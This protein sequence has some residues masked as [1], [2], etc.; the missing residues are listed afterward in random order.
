MNSTKPKG[1]GSVSTPL[2]RAL[3][4]A[5]GPVTV[6]ELRRASRAKAVSVQ[7]R[8][9]RWR[10]AGFVVTLEPEPA[11][12]VI[13]PKAADRQ[14]APGPGDLSADAWRA[15]RRLGRPATFEELLAA[16]GAADRPLYCRLFR[17]RK[18]GFIVKIEARPSRYV[19]SPAA[20]DVAEPPQVS[21]EGEVKE[22]RRTARERLWSA[23]RVLKTFDV[24]MLMM[25]AEAR[26][27]SCEDFINLLARAGY[28]RT[29]NHPVT[30]S[31]AGNNARTWSTYQLTRNTG[32]KAPIIT[33]PRGGE[34]QLVDL[35]TG[36][37]VPIGP[38]LHQRARG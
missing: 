28:L 15:L 12:Y 35:N 10:K 20:P 14:E 23:M 30:R 21:L 5:E 11:R 36:A 26:R 6:G 38:G 33:N 13:A 34:R 16:S 27:R 8:L 18:S 4:S 22:R 19:L 7:Q 17:W 29:L 25:T 37:G 32:P 2:W 24:P 9:Q 1:T 3:R 31:P